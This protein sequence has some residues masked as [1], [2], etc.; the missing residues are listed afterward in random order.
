MKK[1]V[2]IN[3]FLMMFSL[4]GLTSCSSDDNEV[5]FD[6]PVK[7]E[8]VNGDYSGKV[9]TSQGEAKNEGNIA[10]VVGDSI[11]SFDELPVNEIIGSVIEDKEAAKAAIEALG[12]VEYDLNFT[13][14]L[15]ESSTAVELAFEP[16]VLEVV[17]PVEGGEKKIVAT[18]KTEHKGVY[19]S[20]RVNS[21]KFEII[22]DKITVDGVDLNPYE[23]IKY[24]FPLSIKK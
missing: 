21:L 17:V 20:N 4:I 1:I 16:E 8:D 18:F 12:K 3:A 23:V 10:F 2:G 19:T 6:M 14:N 5:Y 9:V 15:N 13:S 22:V 11:I 7:L 24:S